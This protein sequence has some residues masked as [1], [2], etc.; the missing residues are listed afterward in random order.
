MATKKKAADKAAERVV[1]AERGL[2]LREAPGLDSRVLAVLSHGA[3][4]LPAAEQAEG[5]EWVHV[6]T[7]T[8][9]GWVL[10]EYLEPVPDSLE[11]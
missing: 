9:M 4:V 11:G 6:R 7:G 1:T 3:G 2:N 5:A 10:A 8:L